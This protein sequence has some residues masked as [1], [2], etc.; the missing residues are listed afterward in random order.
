M[1]A[2]TFRLITATLLAGVEFLFSITQV[3]DLRQGRIICFPTKKK[4]LTTF[5]E[6]INSS[7]VT[8]SKKNETKGEIPCF[9]SDH[10]RG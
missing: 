3:I 7:L 6:I 1:G 9:Q 5:Q 4:R 2:H 10:H 8:L